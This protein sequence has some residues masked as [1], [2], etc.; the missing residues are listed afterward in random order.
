MIRL[1]VKWAL[2][3]IALVILT[4]LMPGFSYDSIIAVVIAAAILGVLNAIVRPIL[5]LL[6]LPVT[7]VTLGLFLIVINAFML[8]V[9][10]WLVPGFEIRHFGWALLGAVVLSLITLITDRAAPPPRSKSRKG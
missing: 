8:E 7:V 2:A 10:S 3:T 4:W 5:V 9:T 6:T 1:I